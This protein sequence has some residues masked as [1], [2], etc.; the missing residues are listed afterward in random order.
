MSAQGFTCP[1]CGAYNDSDAQW[2]TQCLVP[3]QLAQGPATPRQATPPGWYPD[4]ANPSQLRWW[5]GSSWS[6]TTAPTGGAAAPPVAPSTSPP[7]PEQAPQLLPNLTDKQ[8]NKQLGKE[9]AELARLQAERAQLA[10]EVVE[11]REMAILQ[12]VGIYEYSHPL[13]D[14]AAYKTQLAQLRTQMK[15]A[16][17]EGNAVQGATNWSVNGSV[18]QG[19][20]M[21]KDFSKLMLRA[22]NTEADNCVR[23]LKPHT[24]QS[25]INRLNKA[26]IA[27][28]K[29]GK[30]MQIMITDYYHSLR[31][32]E[33]ELTADYVAKV[34]AEK[35]VERAER[36][37]LREEEKAQREFQRERERLEKE[38]AHYQAA[39]EAIRRSGDAE[40]VAEAEARLA[41]IDEGLT[42]LSERE[43]NIRVGHVYVISNIGAF[44]PGV[45]KI[46]LTRRLTPLDRVRELGDASVP[47][48]YDVHALHFSKDAVGLEAQL[49]EALSEKRVNVVNMRRE[50]FYATPQEVRA[51]LERADG[52]L[53]SYTEDAEAVEWRQSE[54]AR[55]KRAAAAPPPP[56]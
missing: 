13:D 2:C 36:D 44:G 50:F 55:N 12:E 40:E 48:H 51:L 10:L 35:E 8:V 7:T 11:T 54:T 15:T 22:Y 34:A 53:V 42:S 21:V 3:R 14:S 47:F 27:I 16:V 28:V 31:I 37:R 17:K 5:D 23:T 1:R 56:A 38:K 19:A 9:R 4:A 45:V 26:A 46:G 30:T 20:K 25:A 29:L 39:L 18:K 49:H 32:Y 41:E 52:S 24:L 33:L 6:E 43:A